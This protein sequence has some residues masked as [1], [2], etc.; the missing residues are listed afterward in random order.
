MKKFLLLVFLIS[1]SIIFSQSPV[2][3]LTGTLKNQIKN[4]NDS[5]QYLIWVTF[6]RQRK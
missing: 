6:T 4:D 1:P 3:K 5:G 2:N